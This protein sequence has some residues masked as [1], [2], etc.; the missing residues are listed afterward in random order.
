M[1]EISGEILFKSENH[2]DFFFYKLFFFTNFFFYTLTN[3]T[4][5]KD[6]DLEAITRQT[7]RHW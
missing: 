4:D 3:L 1:M 2:F 6:Q 7:E 5:L